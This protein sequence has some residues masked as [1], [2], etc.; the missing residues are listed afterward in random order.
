M[1]KSLSGYKDMT[2]YIT[3]IN[4]L[5]Q[6][7]NSTIIHHQVN[8]IKQ[9]DNYI[10]NKKPLS[11]APKPLG[12]LPDQFE[13]VLA[14]IGE[15]KRSALT[16]INNLFN[17]CRQYL[18]LEY[19]IWS[20]ANL[21]TA[22]LIKEKF[23]VKKALEIMAGNAYW[24][25]AL[26]EVGIKTISTDSLEWAKTSKTGS[27]PFHKVLDMPATQAIEKYRDVDLILCSWAPNFGQSD[28]KAVSAW[29]KYNKSSHLLFIGEQ[30]GATNSREFWDRHWLKKTPE[31]VEINHSFQNFDFI[32]ERI[33]EIDN[34]L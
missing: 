6:E 16:A 33:F 24:S 29:Q 20:I 17:N 27:Q 30:D 22:R 3:K 7:L 8:E 34:E 31:L 4:Q 12:L 14:E 9:I 1:L 15:D 21:Q 28:M 13:D 2:E 32:D 18:S 19:G 26:E 5:D 11:Q 10:K 25:E 23:E